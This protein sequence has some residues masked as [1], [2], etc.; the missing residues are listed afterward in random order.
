MVCNSNKEVR[1]PSL[2]IQHSIPAVVMSWRH[3]LTMIIPVSL[4]ANMTD[5]STVVGLW[6]WGGGGTGWSRGGVGREWCGVGWGG[7]EVGWSRNGVGVVWDRAGV[8]W[9]ISDAGVEQNTIQEQYMGTPS[10]HLQSNM[11]IIPTVRHHIK[12]NFPLTLR[13][14]LELHYP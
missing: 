12:I 10:K 5:T 8:G 14:A 7:A 11:L 9:G 1:S 13:D 4:L 6:G 3:N 2:R